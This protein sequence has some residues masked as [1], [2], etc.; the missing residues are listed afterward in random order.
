M[1]LKEKILSNVVVNEETGCWDWQR[2]KTRN[3]YGHVRVGKKL[4]SS[5]RIS[6]EV[7]LGEIGSNLNVLHKCDNRGCCNPDHL[8]LGTHSDNMRDK[9][10]K[11]RQYKPTGINHPKSKLDESD[12]RA[13]LQDTRSMNDIGASY[14]IHPTVVGKIKSGKLWKHLTGL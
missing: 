3:G 8:F 1:D 2:S 11:N 6:Y 13:I 10:S 9:V 12:V 14:N 7:F 4:K 5:H